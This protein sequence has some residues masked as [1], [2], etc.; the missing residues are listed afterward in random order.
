MSRLSQL[1]AETV[2]RSF[3]PRTKLTG[4]Q[5]ANKYGW[6]AASSGAAEPGKYSTDRAPY[7]AEILD[8]MCDEVH[9]DVVF[10]KAS[11][12]GFTEAINQF[13]GYCMAEDPSGL[14]IVRPSIDD[15]KSWMK[16]R[17]DPMLAESPRLQGIVRSEKGRRVSDDTMQRKVFRGGWLIAIGANSPTG[18]RSRP[19]RRLFGDER[20]GW[21]LDARQQGDPWD[22][23]IEKTSTFWNA[24]RVQG[25][26]PGEE[27]T[28]PITEA[29][30]VSDWREYHLA[31]P[32]CGFREPLRWKATDGTYR[33]VCDL[34]PAN[35]LIPQT[36][37]YLCMACGVL[38]PEEE[39]AR[40]L[41]SGAWVPRFPERKV[42]GFDLNGLISPWRPW[43]D[44][45]DLWV[46]AQRNR[47][48]LKVFV[49]HVLAEPWRHT[50]ERIDVATLRDRAAPM[51]TFPVEIG[52]CFGAVDV[53]KDRLETLVIGVGAAEEVWVL[54]WGVA[55]GDPEK[56][57]TW[58]AAYEMLTAA[59]PAPL[60]CVAIDTGFLTGTA[61]K[62]VDAWNG[63]RGGP[64]VIG[65]K[66]EDGRGRPWIQRP[67][68]ATSRR[69]RRPWLIGSDT[70][71]D[72]LALRLLNPVPPG[73]PG[74][75]HFAD[76]LDPAFFDGL[77][78]EEQRIVLVKGRQTRAWRPIS[79]DRAT[80][81][82]DLTVYAMG[83]LYSFGPQW[84]G[85]LGRLAQQRAE[86]T[87]AQGSA[88]ESAVPAEDREEPPFPNRPRHKSRG[89]V[90]GWKR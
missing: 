23:G 32:H 87:A 66:G 90:Q 69:V 86:A 47:E 73:G 31:C 16:E 33:I 70:G 64:R 22:L 77:T 40:M 13:V 44:I 78:S 34:D 41:R 84:V 12:L 21:T 43:S 59:R 9:R 18:L 5:W 51:E 57:E 76:S 65:V 63:R 38:I 54:E 39:K 88:P 26:T 11:Q 8:V 7:L 29:L 50:A 75:F 61:W 72:A 2:R 80:E 27:E 46:K 68:R 24:K 45:M 82:L 52:A 14:I 3:E 48:K 4:S 79:H 89:Y 20:S 60:W 71:K 30:K 6:V 37:R 35:Q 62:A 74:S 42:V 28:C 81:P 19:S 67:G 17:I 53:Q 49:T 55:E 25:S 36:A 56:V 58:E 85:K 1:A 15:A 10:N 83:A